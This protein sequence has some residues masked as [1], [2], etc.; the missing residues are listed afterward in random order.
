V[1]PS[2]IKTAVIRLR[3]KLGNDAQPDL[4]RTH[5]GI[6]YSFASVS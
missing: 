2:V 1:D 6:G 3:R 4:I 5:R